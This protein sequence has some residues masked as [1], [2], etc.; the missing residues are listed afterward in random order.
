MANRSKVPTVLDPEWFEREAEMMRVMAHP[1]RLMILEVLKPGPRPVGE[2]AGVLGMSLP[3]ASQHL[4]VMRTLRIVRAERHGQTVRYALTSPVLG[5]CCALVRGLLVE[6]ALAQKT[7]AVS[8]RG[9][10]A[11]TVSIATKRILEGARA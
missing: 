7:R 8:A 3:N 5:R 2:I 1:K 6:Q 9:A 11:A 4:R 10:E